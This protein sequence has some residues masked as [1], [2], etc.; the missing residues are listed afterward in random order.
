MKF[1]IATHNAHKVEEFSR[2]LAPLG[3][4]AMADPSLSD[5]EET[6]TTFSE[7][8][9]LKA[10]A[11]CK[12]TGLP[13][14]ADDSGLCVDALNGE[15]GIYSARYAPEGQKKQTILNKL[16]GIPKEQ[17]TARFVC[18]ICCVFP[19]GEMI[20]AQG[21]C[22]GTIAFACRGD[23]GFGYD[24]IFECPDGKT[25]GEKTA[26]E[27]DQYSHRSKALHAFVQ[28][29]EEYTAKENHHDQ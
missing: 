19:N 15:P 18:A 27:K 29:L 13:A 21:V 28:R 23:S 5:V 16:Q 3:I 10:Q 7:N 2:I 17:R 20:T 1:V 11:A 4:E 25:F 22:E 8:A 24:P 9:F 14:V 26:Q 12:E 6:G